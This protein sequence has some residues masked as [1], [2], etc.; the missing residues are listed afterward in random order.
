MI[1]GDLSKK[2]NLGGAKFNGGP[3]NPKDVMFVVLKD[4]ALC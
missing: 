4:I 3:M 1:G 2:L